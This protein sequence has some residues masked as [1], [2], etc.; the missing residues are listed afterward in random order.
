MTTIT[1]N[2]ARWRSVLTFFISVLY[3]G[4]V[5]SWIYLNWILIFLVVPMGL[6]LAW[7]A[8]KS[9]Q[10]L[11]GNRPAL[12]LDKDGI[13]DNTHWYSLGRVA[14]EEVDSIKTKQ[15]FFVQNIQIIFKNPRAVIQKEKRLL[16]KIV[17]SYQLLLKKT[18]MLLN[19]S[20]LAISYNELAT[21][22]R[23]IDFENPDFV[24]MSEHLID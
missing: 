14:W 2:F 19:T 6:F 18:P 5:F 16:K 22:L 15:L 10:E 13:V 20:L 23:D 11:K 21:L 7:Q 9:W 17:Q 12:I 3:L 24:D 1:V 8:K 4:I